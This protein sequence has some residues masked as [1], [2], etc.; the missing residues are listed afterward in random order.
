MQQLMEQRWMDLAYYYSS[1]KQHRRS[2]IMTSFDT[3]LNASVRT[4]NVPSTSN[5]VTTNG[6]LRFFAMGGDMPLDRHHADILSSALVTRCTAAGIAFMSMTYASCIDTYDDISSRPRYTAFGMRP[7]IFD[8]ILEHTA[9]ISMSH[10]LDISAPIARNNLVTFGNWYVRNPNVWNHQIASLH[11]CHI[12]TLHHRVQRHILHD[13]RIHN[14]MCGFG[15]SNIDILHEHWICSYLILGFMI[16]LIMLLQ[17]ATRNH[18]LQTKGL[19]ISIS[20]RR[21]VTPGRDVRVCT[22]LI[23][24]CKYMSIFQVSSNLHR[25]TTFREGNASKSTMVIRSQC[26]NKELVGH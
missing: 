3:N 12:A 8:D 2:A 16:G 14:L 1:R 21:G 4:Y 23:P 7:F 25:Q 5:V 9:C 20:S 15:L 22:D 18:T 24:I 6:E 13:T 19:V 11:Q 10:R 26:R 17:C